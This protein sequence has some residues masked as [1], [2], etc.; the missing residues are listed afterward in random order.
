MDDLEK[1]IAIDIDG[2]ICSVNENYEDCKIINRA[3]ES[4]DL[5]R[6]KGYKVFLHTGRHILNSEVTIKWLK[7]NQINYDH[8]VFGKPP[9]KYYIDDKSIKFDSWD[10]VLNSIEL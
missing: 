3:K 1:I 4:I 10:N 6:S 9:A 8:I 5:I 2:T 7:K